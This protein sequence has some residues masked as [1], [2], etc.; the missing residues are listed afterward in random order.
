VLASLPRGRFRPS[1]RVRK[2]REFEDAQRKGRRVTTPH[3]VLL[4]HARESP[5]TARLGIV[6]SRK[7]GTAVVRNRAKRLV[8]EAFRTARDL[9]IPGIDVVVIARRPLAGLKP[10][11]IVAEWREVAALIE[12]RSREAIRT[13]RRAELPVGPA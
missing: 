3:F 13:R 11:D 7:I 6:A 10:A 2:R 1:D 12:R 8:R 9:F 4:L 5:G